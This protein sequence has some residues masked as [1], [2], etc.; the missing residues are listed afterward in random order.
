[1]TSRLAMLASLTL[2]GWAATAR[3]Q[4]QAEGELAQVQELVVYARYGEAIERAR[5]LLERTDLSAAD[6]NW[7][8][9]IIATAQIANRESRAANQTLE[10]LYQRDPGHRLHDADASPPV[11]SAFARAREAA[12]TPLEVTVLHDPPPL[13]GREPPRILARVERGDDAVA[14]L[15]LAYRTEA[16]A[17]F[18]H[19]VMNRQEDGGWA[20]RIPVV[21][22]ADRPIDVAYYLAALAP[23]GIELGRV[24]SPSEPLQLQIPAAELISSGVPRDDGQPMN[25]LVVM[26]VEDEDE[27]GSIADEPWLWILV[28]SIVVAGAVTTGVV[29]ATTQ[30]QGGPEAGTLGVVMLVAP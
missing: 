25:D 1:M 18:S 23:S 6:R 4:P 30:D 20:A 29:I 26:P 3:A 2:L 27:G 13:R 5:Q 24:G 10:Q 7:A 21:G 12:S 14:E 15:R 28:G 17:G 9:E 19:V 8:L 16:E 22:Q 11:L